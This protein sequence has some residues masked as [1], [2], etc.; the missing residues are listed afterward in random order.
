M[1]DTKSHPPARPISSQSHRSLAFGNGPTT[2]SSQRS[3]VVDWVSYSTFHPYSLTRRLSLTPL[4]IHNS[5]TES[6]QRAHPHA[7]RVVLLLFN[8]TR[9][10]CCCSTQRAHAPDPQARGPLSLWTEVWPT[11]PV[12]TQ[13]DNRINTGRFFSQELMSLL[14]LLLE[15]PGGAGSVQF[16]S[17]QF[18]S[19]PTT[20]T[21][22]ASLESTFDRLLIEA[23][24]R[25]SV[26][27]VVTELSRDTF[28]QAHGHTDEP[29][30][31]GAGTGTYAR[32]IRNHAKCNSQRRLDY[33]VRLE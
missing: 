3:P 5:S 26:V 13:P 29:H 33:G 14:F 25:L 22:T 24:I 11:Q 1:G 32:S 6:T 15:T 17:V 9:M 16:S 21:P 23:S 31:P 30:L 10:C 7:P 27:Y 4:R 20:N 18:S 28:T 19:S 2:R 12:L 8:T